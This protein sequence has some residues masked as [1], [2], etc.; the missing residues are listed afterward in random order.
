MRDA[1]SPGWCGWWCGGWL[2]VWGALL[3]LPGG[4]KV[5]KSEKETTHRTNLGF[6]WVADAVDRAPLD[7]AAFLCVSISFLGVARGSRAAACG[8][9]RCG[10]VAC[11]L[12]LVKRPLKLLS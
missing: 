7:G 9:W 10:G 8:V 11:G 3:L 2:V 12:W 6:A 5:E 1:P 4:L